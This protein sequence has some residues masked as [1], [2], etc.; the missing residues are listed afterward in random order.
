MEDKC[1]SVLIP[2]QDSEDETI[3]GPTTTANINNNDNHNESDNPH[4]KTEDALVKLC[5]SQGGDE[6]SFKDDNL[7]ES[8]PTQD[9]HAET[10]NRVIFDDILIQLGEFGLEQKINY[11]LFSLPYILTSM[12][13]M[14]WVFVGFSPQHRCRVPGDPLQQDFQGDLLH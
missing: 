9:I 14:G 11:V 10:K 6:N 1:K 13:L 4:T 8:N 3:E 2:Q 7:T 12:Q 5:K